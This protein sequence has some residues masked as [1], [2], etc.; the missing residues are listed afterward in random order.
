MEPLHILYWADGQM[1]KELPVL[2]QLRTRV[3][4]SLEF[5]REDMKRFLNPTP[6]KV[7]KPKPAIAPPIRPIIRNRRIELKL[8]GAYYRYATII[9]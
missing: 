7:N 6:Y 1:Q 5:L 9:Q 2:S 3:E 4:N 8:R